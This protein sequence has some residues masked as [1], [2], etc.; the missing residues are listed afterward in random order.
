MRLE[1]VESGHSPDRKQMLDAIAQMAGG[2]APSVVKT[3][4]YRP[5]FFGSKYSALTHEAMRGPSEWTPGERE[6][7]AAFV[8]RVNQCPF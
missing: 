1:C 5:E 8:S 3:M 6:L 4:F 2:E 7:F